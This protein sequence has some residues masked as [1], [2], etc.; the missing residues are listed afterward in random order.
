MPMTAASVS[1]RSNVLNMKWRYAG[2]IAFIAGSGFG[3]RLRRA[4]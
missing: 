1:I 2:G 3:K 4:G